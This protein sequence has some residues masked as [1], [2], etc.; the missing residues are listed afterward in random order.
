MKWGDALLRPL[1]EQAV[2]AFEEGHVVLPRYRLSEVE[3]VFPGCSRH[4]KGPLLIPFADNRAAVVLWH[5]QWKAAPIKLGQEHAN[6]SE[7]HGAQVCELGL[8]QFA[9]HVLEKSRLPLGE[10]LIQRL[11]TVVALERPTQRIRMEEYWR[12]PPSPPITDQVKNAFDEGH[13]VLTGY[14][15]SEV[16]AKFPGCGDYVIGPLLVPIA[17]RQTDVVVL[18]HS[19]KKILDR[20]ETRG[21]T[22][23]PLTYEFHGVRVHES[24]LQEFALHVLEESRLRLGEHLIRRLRRVLNTQPPGQENRADPDPPPPAPK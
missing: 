23:D 12:T 13:A 16:G 5:S 6:P 9:L 11:Q 24:V 3:E 10:H 20:P 15:S 18:W 19:Q 1:T 2:Y 22:E 4:A 7:F 17:D 14:R 21:Y 8:Q